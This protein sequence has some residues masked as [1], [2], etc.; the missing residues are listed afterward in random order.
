LKAGIENLF[1]RMMPDE[2][3]AVEAIS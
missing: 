1:K 3:N 2:V